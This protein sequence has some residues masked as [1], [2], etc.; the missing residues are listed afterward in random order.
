MSEL[1]NGR[2]RMTAPFV[3]VET[4]FDDA[5]VRERRPRR[6]ARRT[7]LERLRAWL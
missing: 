3:Y 1:S 4:S 2:F 5:P 7:R 6:P